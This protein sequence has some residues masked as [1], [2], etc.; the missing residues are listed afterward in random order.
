MFK[1][2]NYYGLDLTGIKLRIKMIFTNRVLM[3][4]FS[5]GAQVFQG[6]DG[7]R[8]T[9]QKNIPLIL[10]HPPVNFLISMISLP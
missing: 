10:K 1:L 7:S 5:A 8:P 9:L 3:A 2:K 4:G 6:E